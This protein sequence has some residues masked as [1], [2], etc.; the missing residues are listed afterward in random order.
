L[1]WFRYVPG[2]DTGPRRRPAQTRRTRQLASRAAATLRSRPTDRGSSCRDGNNLGLG[3]EEG[4]E[5]RVCPRRRSLGRPST[6]EIEATTLGAEPIWPRPTL[7]ACAPIHSLRVRPWAI[8]RSPPSPSSS[9]SRVSASQHPRK[10][11][12]N[13]TQTTTTN[14]Y[15]R[16]HVC[17]IRIGTLKTQGNSN[18]S[19]VG[20][21]KSF[22]GYRSVDGRTAPHGVIRPI[23]P[24]D[25]DT[26]PAA[27]DA[28]PLGVCGY[29]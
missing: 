3:R 19:A 6:D 26:T 2:F 16:T 12:S 11:M 1:W 5:A 4:S 13:P 17:R 7:H 28:R 15:V 21:Q 25:E 20:Q 10:T 22:R 18:R 8:G 29:G 23:K 14:S 24:V 9:S 27:A